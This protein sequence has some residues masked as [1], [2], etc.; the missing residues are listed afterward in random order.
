MLFLSTIRLTCNPTIHAIQV[1]R[2]NL[3][4]QK[5]PDW[6]VC[7]SDRAS[8]ATVGRC[9]MVYLESGL[10]GWRPLK[11]SFLESLPRSAFNQE[12]ISSLD[13]LFEWLVPPILAQVKK[14]DLFV[15]FSELHLVTCMI[16]L[17]REV[18]AVDELV[19]EHIEDGF[20]YHLFPQVS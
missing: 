18:L 16:R 9:G 3:S 20:L 12:Q 4:Q 17:L 15:P 2:T 19:S 11:D 5:G 1:R 13:E 8:P 6:I 7:L 14:C 10:L